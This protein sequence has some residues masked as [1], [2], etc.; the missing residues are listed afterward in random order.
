M[1]ILTFIV[2][3]FL[4]YR[5]QAMP[6]HSGIIN[7]LFIAIF[8]V[9]AKCFLIFIPQTF[10]HGN[11]SLFEISI[12]SVYDREHTYVLLNIQQIKLEKIPLLFD[13]CACF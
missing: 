12:Y 4:I 2:R 10:S 9:F 1:H 8:L 6:S 5:K 11:K 3:I 13:Q 7:I